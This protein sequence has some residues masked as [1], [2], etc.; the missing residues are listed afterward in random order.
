MIGRL[1]AQVTQ[2]QLRRFRSHV[3]DRLSDRGESGPHLHGERDIVEAD[4]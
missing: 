3:G 2:Q 4:D 1:T